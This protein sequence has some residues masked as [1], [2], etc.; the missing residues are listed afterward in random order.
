GTGHTVR[1]MGYNPVTNH[2]L[3]ASRTGTAAIHRIDAED[4]SYVGALD[5]TGI[6]GGTFVINKVEVTSDG[7][8]YAGNVTTDATGTSTYRLYRWADEE[9]VPVRVYVGNP[10]DVAPEN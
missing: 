1:G 8:I 9:S 6:T 2:L 5:M 10:G 7:V 3:V 4:G